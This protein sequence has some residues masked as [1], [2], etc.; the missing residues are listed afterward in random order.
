MRKSSLRRRFEIDP[1]ACKKG[2]V[3]F[4]AENEVEFSRTRLVLKSKERTEAHRRRTRLKIR[5]GGGNDTGGEL[6]VLVVIGGVELGVA[7][8]GAVAQWLIFGGS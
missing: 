8:E 4:I 1:K 6:R 7:S 3:G 5:V 2:S